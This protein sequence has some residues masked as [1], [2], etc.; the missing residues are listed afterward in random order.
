MDER[1]VVVGLGNPGPSYALNRHNAGYMVA[2]LLA[3]RLGARFA[4]QRRT[5]CEVLD[6][7]IAGVPVTL[8]KPRLYMNESG[9]PVKAVCEFYKVTPDRL[10]V[11]HDELDLPYGVLRLKFGGGD[12]GHNGLKSV[13]RVLGTREYY[14]VRLGVGRPPGRQDPAEYVLRDFSAAE[15]KDLDLNIDRAA[16]AVLD[17]LANGLGPTQNTYHPATPTR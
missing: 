16:D 6:T 8:A 2:D 9:G 12:N 10:V 17:L 5:R 11:V 4:L 7:R 13:S 3:S 1:Y 15:R 14:R